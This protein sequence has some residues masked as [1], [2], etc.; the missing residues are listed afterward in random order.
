MYA[1]NQVPEWLHIP[2]VETGYVAPCKSKS[3]ECLPLLFKMHNQ[4]INAWTMILG[5]IISTILFAFAR[6]TKAASPR[7]R[8][9][10]LFWL[11]CVVH[12]PFS[13]AYHVCR[14]TNEK[15]KLMWKN[16]DLILIT[17]SSLLLTYVLCTCVFTSTVTWLIMSVAIAAAWMYLKRLSFKDDVF[18]HGDASSDKS[19]HVNHMLFA[20]VMYALPI[21]YTL[22]TTQ[23][24][25][26]VRITAALIATL[27]AT[28][29]IYL[30]RFPEKYYPVTFD[31]VGASHQWVHVGFVVAYI[32]E[33]FFLYEHT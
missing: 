31:V 14:F 24:Q 18:G 7:L 30:L 4:T 27:V 33:F 22:L 16:L 2:F 13:V 10:T 12:A 1:K 20:V 9:F 23:N 25:T 6:S 26:L 5:A 3:F 21:I 15:T 17:F 29:A 19:K 32:L 28:A 8:V 11:S